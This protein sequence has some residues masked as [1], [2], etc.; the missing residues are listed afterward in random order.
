MRKARATWF[1][2]V[3]YAVCG[4]VHSGCGTA[5]AS[6]SP[7]EEVYMFALAAVLIGVV[8]VI[9]VRRRSSRKKTAV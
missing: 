9:Y 2:S 3:T 7:T 5:L 1:I 8:G 4:A 6:L